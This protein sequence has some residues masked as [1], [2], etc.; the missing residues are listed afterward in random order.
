VICANKDR[1][2]FVAA[3]VNNNTANGTLAGY[4]TLNQVPDFSSSVS[5]NGVLCPLV[6]DQAAKD[7]AISAGTIAGAAVGAAAAAALIGVGGKKGYDYLMAKNMPIGNVGNNPMY[8][9]SGGAGEN[10]L[11]NS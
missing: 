9:P 7:A 8:A 11:F 4:C 6:Y 5:N 10:P 3:C 2:C 1:G